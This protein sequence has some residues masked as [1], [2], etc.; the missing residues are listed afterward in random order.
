MWQSAN[1]YN[2][3]NIQIENNFIEG[4]KNYGTLG[5]YGV[6][7][8]ISQATGYADNIKI[9]GNT[10]PSSGG[11]YGVYINVPEAQTL[12]GIEVSG[13]SFPGTFANEAFYK[14]I[15]NSHVIFRQNIINGKPTE[16]SGVTSSIASG[17]WIAHGLPDTPTLVVV[18]PHSL[19]SWDVY[20]RN[21]THFQIEFNS[22]SHVIDWYAEYHP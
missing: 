2:L 6:F 4:D 7:L 16:N 22:G 15:S 8:E 1:G 5:A 9:R 19:V 17:T 12:N 13:N 20:D 18:T 11:D 21:S 3:T 14:A 10:I